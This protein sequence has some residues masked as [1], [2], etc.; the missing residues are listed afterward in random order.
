MNVCHSFTC[1]HVVCHSITPIF[2]LFLFFWAGTNVLCGLGLIT[3]PYAIKESGWLGLLILTFFGVI[4]CYTGILLKRC[5]ESS[6][7]LQTYPDI[8]QAAFGIT[9]RCI[10]SVSFQF[11]F[12]KIK[13]LFKKL[14]CFF[15]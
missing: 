10:I 1:C 7:G 15:N 11:P 13:I 2:I 8:G 4:T 6:P 14:C 3:M 9:G 5:L 12:S